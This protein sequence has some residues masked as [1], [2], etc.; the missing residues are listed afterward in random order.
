MQKKQ[1]N[2][3]SLM[4]TAAPQK[5]NSA[6]PAPKKKNTF[7][8]QPKPVLPTGRLTINQPGNSG[9]Y[10][11]EQEA[12]AVADKIMRM[13][14]P[15]LLPEK[16]PFFSPPTVN[17]QQTMATK[18]ALLEQEDH[19]EETEAALP[20]IQTKLSFDAIPPPPDDHKK[21]DTASIQRKCAHCEE[22][23]KK[24]QRKENNAE[25]AVSQH[26]ESYIGSLSGGRFLSRDE[27]SFF[28]PR[29]DYDF[30]NVR[31]HTDSA[32][33]KSAQSIKALAYTTGNNIVFRANQYQPETNEGK[34]LL[35]HEL[36]HVIQQK[37]NGL[38]LQRSVDEDDITD[39]PPRYSF[40]TRCGWID[41]SHADGGMTAQLLQ[42]IK[43]ASDAMRASGETAPMLVTTPPMESHGGPFLLSSVTPSFRIKR[44]LSSDEVLSVALRVFM[45][46]S[47]AF[48]NLQQWT[49][50]LGESS[51]SAEDLPSNI[52]AFY[53]AA[54]NFSRDDITTICDVMDADSSL[55]EFETNEPTERNRT[56]SPLASSLTT[57]WPVELSSITPADIDGPLMDQ[58]T[59][60]LNTFGGA[61][62]DINLAE[63]NALLSGALSVVSISGNNTIDISSTESSSAA[64]NH[65]E[66][67][68][69]GASH[70]YM[71]RWNM[72][73]DS[74][75]AYA[76]WSDSGG[77]HQY[78]SANNAYIGSGTRALLRERGITTARVNCRI[79]ISNAQQFNEVFRLRVNF[80]W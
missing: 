17:T 53:M 59:G 1:V 16:K 62:R 24:I 77:V 20:D 76:M 32:A 68:G 51:F 45:L 11:D 64:G 65:F 50:A 27:R 42:S 22:E 79:A 36:T 7:F 18:P 35:A 23:E 43:G 10:R 73:D 75:N 55:A 57:G 70:N 2:S 46:Q 8:F 61:A 49:D 19:I 15:A 71:F 47:L 54:S 30:N 44:P 66:V 25:A 56:F 38:A 34:K 31:L 28:E 72:L 52:I 6:T 48:E 26:I 80:T 41:W 33:D 29:M 63:Y 74:D 14:E 69:L 3:D 40:S 13:P 39:T 58:P 4:Q 67:A 21:N 60:T 5:Q 9:N 12:D 78:S 37:Q